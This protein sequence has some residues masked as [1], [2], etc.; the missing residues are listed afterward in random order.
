MLATSTLKLV[1]TNA[2]N[3]YP[4][5]KTYEQREFGR[6]N[7]YLQALDAEGWVEQ[8]YCTDWRVFQVVS[9]IGSGSRIGGLRVH[10]WVGG[11]PTV[12]REVMQQIWGHFDALE[13]SQMYA[14]FSAAVH[15]YLEVEASTPDQAGSQEVEGF[16]GKRPLYA[17]QVGR[18]WELACH[19]WDVYV[20]R[21]RAARL[22]PAAVDLLAENLHFVNLPLDRERGAALSS[23]PIVFQL[24]DSGRT[25]SLDPAAERPRLAPATDAGDAKLVIA[26]PDEE[27][28]RFVSG[29]HFVPGGHPHLEVARGTLQE[30]AAVRRAFR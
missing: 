26:G 1:T 4:R 18:T 8:S 29:R 10:A 25:Y 11:G 2:S 15:D 22:D 16:A 9:H 24:A 27:V 6:L 17:Y 13:P 5:I 3:P 12:T 14:S 7:D 19:S 21:D 23:G 30:L 20:S 28:I